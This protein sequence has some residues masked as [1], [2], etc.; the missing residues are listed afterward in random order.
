LCGQTNPNHVYVKSYTRSDGTYVPGY[1]RTAPNSTNTDNFS[2]KGNINPYT[3]KPGWIP[4]D[5]NSNYSTYPS[6]NYNSSG[7]TDY[8]SSNTYNSS[9]K[10]TGTT[11]SLGEKVITYTNG[12][13]VFGLCSFCTDVVYKDNLD[14]Y[15]YTSYSGV[16]KTKGGAGGILL[17][18]EYKFYNENGKL[19]IKENYKKG[20]EHGDYVSWDEDGNIKEKGNFTN[21]VLDYTKFTIEDGY[22]IEWKGDF[23]SKGSIKNV[24]TKYGTL[25]ETAIVGDNL[26]FH[27]KTFYEYV[28]K[29]K[30]EFTSSIGDYYDGSYKAWYQNGIPKVIGNF[31]ENFKDGDWKYFEEDS[32][33][34]VVKYRIYVEKNANGKLKVKGNQR[35]DRYSQRW[36][37]DGEWIYFKDNGEDWKAVK[38]YEDGVQVEKK[39]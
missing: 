33:F 26:M 30:S 32:S 19:L 24:Y 22:V 18:G 36:L 28:G 1:Y 13:E 31:T 37:K 6:T 10:Y 8:N 39:K 25:I 4:P 23:F 20:I 11:N 3:G 2:T 34:T 38:Y 21:G 16:Q 35:Y 17:D 12:Q 27:Y 5:N 7:S 9:A 15:W 14:Y 29:L